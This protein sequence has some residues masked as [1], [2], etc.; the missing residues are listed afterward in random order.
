MRILIADDDP[1]IIRMLSFYLEASGFATSAARDCVQVQMFARQAVDAILLDVH[2]P[3]GT[4]VDTLKKLK[5]SPQT[6]NI[7]V[8][9]I[10]ADP[11]PHL[12]QETMSLGAA[13]FLP[14]PIDLDR[15]LVS[16]RASL[17]LT[18]LGKVT[19]ASAADLSEP[20][21]QQDPVERILVAEDDPFHRRILEKF[22]PSWGYNVQVVGDGEAALQALLSDAAPRLALLDWMMPGLDGPAV[23]RRVREQSG[24]PYTY[25]VL[26]TAKGQKKDLLEGMESGAD[27]YLVKPFDAQE[28]QARL[29]TG[30]RILQLQKELLQAQEEL[31]HQATHDALTKIPNRAAILDDLRRGLARD[32]REQRSTSVILADVDYFKKINDTH[33]H[34]A[35]DVTLREVARRLASLVRVYDRVGRYGGEEFLVVAHNCG[36]AEAHALAERLRLGVSETPVLLPDGRSIRVTLSLGV[37]I[38]PIAQVGHEEQ[39]IAEADVALYSAKRAGRN[40]VEMSPIPTVPANSQEVQLVST[41]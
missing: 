5:R 38:S 15:L 12:P 40:R 6:K 29:R 3:G 22:L 16:L 9:M 30:K 7:P 18:D 36:R 37:A 27:D 14:K 41:P 24:R 23:C 4:G 21:G 25:I 28:L 39:L 17:Q 32:Q 13:D 35:G 19:T 33:G 34:Q 31:R 1:E 8:L 2:L 20:V 10:S 11:N 26:L